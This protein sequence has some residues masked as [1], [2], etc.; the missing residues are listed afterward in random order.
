[1]S[2]ASHVNIKSMERLMKDPLY[3]NSFFM[4]INKGTVVVTGFL[5]WMLAARY[6]SVNE[7]GIATALISGS[8]LIVCFSTFGFEM[9]LVRF[10]KSYDKSRA[11]YTCLFVVTGA[12][13]VISAAYVAIVQYIS[14]DL[15][16][17][18]QFPYSI[19]FIAFTVI[20]A[21]AAITSNTFL[22][23]RDT[24]YTFIQNVLQVVRIPALIPLA[25]FGSIGIITADMF[26]YLVAYLAVFVI[27]GRFIPF[28]PQLDGEFI[29][30]SFKFSFGNYVSNIMYN[31]AFL[32]TPI[33]ILNI[34]GDAANGIFY[35][36]FSLANFLLQIPMIMSVS[37]FVEGVYGENIRKSLVKSGK[38]IAAL[39][40]PGI[41]VV[42]I[43]G[44]DILRLFGD[45]Y[46]NGAD[47]LRLVALSSIAFSV[48]SLFQPILNIRMRISMLATLNALILVLL[49]SLSYLFVS[50]AGITGIG[51]AMIATFTIVDIVIVIVAIKWGWLSIKGDILRKM[52]P[53]NV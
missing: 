12:A 39:L 28:K 38:S 3:R 20:T 16:F 2:V 17:I 31:A 44:P 13:L 6:Y 48:Y 40:V 46:V 11:F 22:A 7:V 37:F 52:K 41:L 45:V 25:V 24:R 36:A 1:M 51:Y 5:F 15:S 32:L 26:G 50:M 42:W 49:T 4:L 30:K 8:T 53:E 18:Q 43:F 10:L 21:I 35:I 47:L 19:V 14:H 9:S 23:L 29:K 33:I 27:I 34:E